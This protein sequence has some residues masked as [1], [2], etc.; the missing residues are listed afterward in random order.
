MPNPDSYHFVCNLKGLRPPIHW[1]F[2]SIDESKSQSVVSDSFRPLA[3]SPAGSLI[4]GILQARILEWVAIPFSRGSFRPRDRTRSPALHADSLPAVTREAQLSQMA[5]RRLSSMPP[6]A[7]AT[8]KKHSRASSKRCHGTAQDTLLTSHQ[9]AL[10][11]DMWA[12][13]RSWNWNF[14]FILRFIYVEQKAFGA[15]GNSCIKSLR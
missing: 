11:I 12:F 15:L 2:L 14:F 4:H 13:P 10:T 8:E 9:W 6:G 1:A 3:C 5:S 7:R